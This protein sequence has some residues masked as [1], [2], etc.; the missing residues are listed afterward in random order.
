GGTD[1]EL[2][3]AWRY[4]KLKKLDS[5]ASTTPTPATLTSQRSPTPLPPSRFCHTYDL[6][7][8]MSSARIEAA[9]P[10]LLDLRG[11]FDTDHGKVDDYAALLKMLGD[12]VDGGGFR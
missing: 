9:D 5:L 7:K 2:T 6:T 3:I 12:A 4:K 10:M 1:D 11:G 8:L